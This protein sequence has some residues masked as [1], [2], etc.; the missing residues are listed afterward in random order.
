MWIKAYTPFKNRIEA[1]I[2]LA[3]NAFPHHSIHSEVFCIQPVPQSTA[4][5]SGI[6][7]MLNAVQIAER[8]KT[9]SA[10]E[11]EGEMAVLCN[12]WYGNSNVVKMKKQIQW[13]ANAWKPGPAE[14]TICLSLVTY[15]N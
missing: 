3:S 6:H 8:F 4:G 10:A 12:G 9:L 11:T 15:F 2:K 5:S 7:V 13:I 14:S 1:I